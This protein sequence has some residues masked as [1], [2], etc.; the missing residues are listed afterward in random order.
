MP[1]RVRGGRTVRLRHL[2]GAS[3]GLG[4]GGGML[5]AACGT[6]PNEPEVYRWPDF[7]ELPCPGVCKERYFPGGVL[8]PTK[9]D[10]PELIWRGRPS[11][12]PSCS[13]VGL[14]PPLS[15]WGDDSVTYYAVGDFYSDLKPGGAC[16]GCAC[17]PPQCA[18]PEYLGYTVLELDD[19]HKRPGER[20]EAD[21]YYGAFDGFETAGAW[22]GTCLRHDAVPAAPLATAFVLPSASSVLCEPFVSPAGLD[23]LVDTV[24]RVCRKDFSLERECDNNVERCM[25]P[26][27]EGFRYCLTLWTEGEPLDEP[28]SCPPSYPERSQVFR[29]IN[30]CDP[31]ACTT[32]TPPECTVSLSR[33]RDPECNDLISTDTVF[34]PDE[35]GHWAMYGRTCLEM[36]AEGT[37]GG[38]SATA[39][40][41]REGAC[42]VAGGDQVAEPRLEGR[43]VLCCEA[44]SGG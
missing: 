14:W 18:M 11:E 21:V 12:A 6:T 2:L 33:Y 40:T 13:S 1:S 34:E 15:H 36:P 7:P 16:P 5:V 9:W 4:L 28:T 37:V 23:A 42:E 25:P 24:W 8:S 3:L 22:D 44:A 38:V 20:C 39:V 10:G 32:V 41:H 29:Y 19:P 43:Y 27:P 17:T 26:A 30:G 35:G 31:C